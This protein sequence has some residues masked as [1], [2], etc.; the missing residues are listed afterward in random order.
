VSFLRG[1]D[2]S[3]GGRAQSGTRA[4]LA[5][6]VQRRS[7]RSDR[8]C[9]GTLACGGCDAPIP[10][11]P[12]PLSLSAELACGFCG[13]RGPARDFLSLARPTRPAHVAVH[14]TRPPLGEG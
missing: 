1:T 8:L 13:H 5:D 6:V 10:A 4:A 14:V 11:G 3:G 7:D 2:R 12:A 9:A